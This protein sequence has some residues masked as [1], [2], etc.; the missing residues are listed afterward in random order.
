MSF[1]RLASV[2]VV[3]AQLMNTIDFRA[4]LVLGGNKRSYGPQDV[5]P[6][7]IARVA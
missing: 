2:S 1:Q 6:L 5:D 7:S 4:P 3:C